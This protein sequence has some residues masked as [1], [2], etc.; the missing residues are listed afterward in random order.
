M[1]DFTRIVDNYAVILGRGSGRN[2]L[3]EH[4]FPYGGRKSQP[5]D[6]VETRQF[7]LRSCRIPAF[8]S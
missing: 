2:E 8:R 5:T 1:V 4:I 6:F 3:V 7:A